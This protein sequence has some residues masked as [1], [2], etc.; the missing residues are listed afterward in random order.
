MST[1]PM[2]YLPAPCILCYAEFLLMKNFQVVHLTFIIENY[3][4]HFYAVPEYLLI[5]CRN[6]Y[7]PIVLAGL[8]YQLPEEKLSRHGERAS[9]NIEH[10]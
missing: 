8:K 10:C 2:S 5:F 1:R 6:S 3:T 4:F 9:G 7:S